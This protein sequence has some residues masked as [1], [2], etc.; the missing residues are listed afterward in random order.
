MPSLISAVNVNKRKNPH[1]L[2]Y[3]H[4][5]KGLVDSATTVY[6]RKISMLKRRI[7][8]VLSLT[9]LLISIAL[10]AAETDYATLTGKIS[11]PSGAV[12]PEARIDLRNQESGQTRSLT[13]DRYGEFSATSLPSGIYEFL[14]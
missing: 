8:I 6:E 3:P 10:L 9:A 14:V 7:V 4:R 1:C 2:L 11:G 12:I 13:T 5:T